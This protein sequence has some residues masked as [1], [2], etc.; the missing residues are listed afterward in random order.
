MSTTVV[1]RPNKHLTASASQFAAISALALSSVAISPIFPMKV[2]IR[3][4]RF[5][6]IEYSVEA[7]P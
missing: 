4:H 7:Q 3:A 5:N 1:V 6:R 2:V